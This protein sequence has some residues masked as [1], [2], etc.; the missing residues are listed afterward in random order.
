M[1]IKGANIDNINNDKDDNKD[2]IT[3]KACLSCLLLVSWFLPLHIWYILFQIA[4]GIYIEIHLT[5][6]GIFSHK[7]TQKVV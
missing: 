5:K 4:S 6:G 2:C 1:Y 7:K 3:N